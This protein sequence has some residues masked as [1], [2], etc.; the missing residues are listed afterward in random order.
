MSPN[1]ESGIVA[2]R[3]FRSETDQFSTPPGPRTIKTLPGIQAHKA[4]VWSCA[5]PRI[6][7]SKPCLMGSPATDIY[8]YSLMDSHPVSTPQCR[9]QRWETTTDK[10]QSP[11]IL[12]CPN[13]RSSVSTV[14]PL[15]VHWLVLQPFFPRQTPCLAVD[16]ATDFRQV[17]PIL[18]CRTTSQYASL[19]GPMN[20]HATPH[21]PAIHYP[22]F[23][24]VPTNNQR[25]Q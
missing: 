22:A 15:E 4:L 13:A 9:K 19:H 17:L 14:Y 20:L 1:R 16:H 18:L 11:E 5:T 7:R 8:I 3:P 12:K 23:S 2:P 21:H 6:S 10:N 24:T 25:S